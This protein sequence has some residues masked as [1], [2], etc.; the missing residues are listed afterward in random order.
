MKRNLAK[1]KREGSRDVSSR[2]LEPDE[3]DVVEVGE[4]TVQHR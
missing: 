1:L 3:P 2:Y 4:L